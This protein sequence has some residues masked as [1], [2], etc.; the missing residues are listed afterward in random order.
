MAVI[1]RDG[2]VAPSRPHPVRRARL[3]VGSVAAGVTLA[4]LWSF[5]LVDHVIGDSVANS[6][7]GHDAK[8]TA[9]GGT[10]AG[11][12]FALVSGL[13]GTFT[14]CNIAM[15]ASIG[16]LSSASARTAGT[17]ADATAARRA[18]ASVAGR[19]GLRTLL[20]PLGWLLLGAVTV[21]ACYGF[22]GVLLGDRL[23]QLST[24]TVGDMPVR[25][26]QSAVVFG[27]VG[28][29]FCYLGLAVLGVLPDPFARRPVARVVTL[30]ALI[31]GFLI[32]RPFPLFT[33]LFRWAVEE[34]NP[35]YGAAAFVLQ[36]V[37][38]ILV[39]AALFAVLIAGSRGRFL[40]WLTGSPVR[41]A[42][43]SGALLLALGVFTV[44]YWDIRLPARFGYGWFP[45]LPYNS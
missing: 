21:S 5:E 17:G 37:G 34:G 2:P 8:A 30:G 42:A 18:S 36:S 28:L 32:G 25:L 29:A 7:L 1:N 6:L 39:V 19:N 35:L 33:K 4:V 3:I 20:R 22:V 10:V 38:N 26:V 24:A 12:T 43:I 41:A 27:V 31:G 15:A 9:I 45:T 13:A 23:P 40:R 14:A 11:L 16:P 44:V